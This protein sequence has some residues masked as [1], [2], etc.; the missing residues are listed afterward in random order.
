MTAREEQ[1]LKIGFEAGKRAIQMHPEND[2][3]DYIRLREAREQVKKFDL[4][5]VGDNEVA[6]RNAAKDLI[7]LYDKDRFDFGLAQKVNA[8]EKALKQ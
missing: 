7:S 4:G 8:L 2:D 6:L 3:Y 1:I 5:D